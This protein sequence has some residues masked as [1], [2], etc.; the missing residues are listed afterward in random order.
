[1]EIHEDAVQFAKRLEE[2]MEAWQKDGLIEP[3]QKERILAR[4][5]EMGEIREKA[6]PGKLVTTISVLGAVLVGV[7]VILFIASNW[8]EIPSWGRLSMIFT[9]MFAAYGGGYHI[10]YG[11]GNFPRVGAALILLGALIYGA[12]I[13]LIAQMY[14][15]SVHYPN[16]PLL[17]GVGTLPLAYLLR[18][19]SLLVLALIDLL[20]WLGMEGSFHVTDSYGFW[21]MPMFMLFLAA[22]LML[23]AVGL[24]HRCFDGLK[25]ISNPYLM[26]GILG[27]FAGG[28][29]MTFSD[30][31]GKVSG[32]PGLLPFYSTIA[33]VFFIAAAIRIYAGE[34]EK[35]LRAE[36]LALGG[37]MC[38]VLYVVTLYPGAVSDGSKI[39]PAII[40]NLVY[41]G[42]AIGLVTLGYL[43][44]MPMYV[45][46]G[47]VFFVID[48]IARYFDFFWKLLPRS[49]F[50]IG[51]GGVLLFVGIYLEKK[52]RRIMES[53]KTK[54]V[55]P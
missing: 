51:G 50:F 43:R 47:L 5:R 38:I 22:G 18:F 42:A 8:S 1:M 44:R 41:A 54:E 3:D 4:Y 39:V 35:G 6:G 23:W 27:A 37:F 26:T 21:G 13:F 52:R 34:K 33:V 14:H 49:L 9:G 32:Y 28:F 24:V 29:F 2:E 30:A 55:Q 45:N 7:G 16:G 19:R 53:F 17:W 20:I 31:F 25:A 46:A 10:R 15:I 12:G 40:F 48:I 36:I 11:K